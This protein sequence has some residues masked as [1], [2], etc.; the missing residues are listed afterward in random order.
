R[1]P[2]KPLDDVGALL[3]DNYGGLCDRDDGDEREYESYYQSGFHLD[4]SFGLD[5]QREAFD[6][7]HFTAR[8]P[9]NKRLRVVARRPRRASELD[10]A[11]RPGRKILGGDGR[12]THDDVHARRL[13][14]DLERLQ[15]P[16]TERRKGRNR[17]DRKQQHLHPLG[18]GKVETRE[19]ADGE[20]TEA[21]EDDVKAARRGQLGHDEYETQHQ[22]VPP[23]DFHRMRPGR[24]Y[25]ATLHAGYKLD[26]WL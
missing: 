22:P 15:Q 26:S 14:I 13:R 11:Q 16:A 19:H 12:F 8:T 2:A 10:R 3:R 20:R 18:A 6:A 24:D 9:R 25:M 21:E 5:V 7:R 1:K 23:E 17:D 4:G